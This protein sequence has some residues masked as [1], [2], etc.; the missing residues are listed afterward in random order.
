M[1][2]KTK[3]RTAAVNHL[4]RC[5]QLAIP[6]PAQAGL[7]EQRRPLSLRSEAFLQLPIASLLLI[8]CVLRFRSVNSVLYRTDCS[9]QFISHPF[10][11]VSSWDVLLWPA[12]ACCWG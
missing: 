6:G 7:C 8:V 4:K 2:V 12:L 11:G 10:H 1:Q 3:L 9:C 5:G